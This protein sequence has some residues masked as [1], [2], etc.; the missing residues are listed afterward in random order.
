MRILLLSDWMSN[1]GGAEN[2]ILSLRDELRAQGD[3]VRLLSCGAASADSGTSDL[4]AYGSDAWMAQAFLQVVNPFAVSRVREVLREFGPDVALVSQ[5]AYHLSP[6]ILRALSPVPTVVTMMDYKAICPTG[7]RL[8][9]DGSLCAVRS[10]ITCNHNGCV[11]LAHWLRDR[12]RYSLLNSGLLGARRVICASTWM[13]KE[14]HEAGIDATTIP[15]GVP[16]RNELA[17]AP[18][19]DPTF[20]YVGRLSREKGVAV[21]LAAFARLLPDFPQARLRI[22]GDGPLRLQLDALAA[23]L[24]IHSAVEFRGWFPRERL[25]ENLDDVWCVAC[26]SLWAEP[27]GLAAVESIL[28]GIPVIASDTGGFRETIEEGV[29]GMMAATGSVSSLESKLRLVAARLQF[30]SHR[31]SAGA[32]AGTRSKYAMTAHAIRVKQVL[33]EILEPARA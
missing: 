22:L 32:M 12:P 33:G 11:G 15:L 28:L 4:R 6:A 8:L 16:E 27:F 2:Y 17:G 5:F 1:R 10:G 7:T 20:A 25:R 29:N 24:G 30:P 18:A 26:P 14:L 23:S 13:E 19:N 21:L 3:E 31:L 9:P